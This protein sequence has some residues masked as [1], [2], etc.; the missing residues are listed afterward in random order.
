MFLLS[1]SPA[2]R[3]VAQ[4]CVSSA[5]HGLST[6]VFTVARTYY[7]KIARLFSRLFSPR[8]LNGSYRWYG[9]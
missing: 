3:G 4:T 6:P 7:L 9:A 8:E 5:R 2:K 1:F